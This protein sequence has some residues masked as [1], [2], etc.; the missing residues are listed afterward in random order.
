MTRNSH[1][2]SGHSVPG[3][4]PRSSRRRPHVAPP[5]PQQTGGP[6]PRL[7]TSN[8][9]TQEAPRAVNRVGTATPPR[10]ENPQSL[11]TA[12]R[13]IPKTGRMK[14][15]EKPASWDESKTTV[16]T[17]P[18]ERV[19]GRARG[20]THASCARALL[21]TSPRAARG[22]RLFPRFRRTRPAT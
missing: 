4:V 14:V 7:Q 11:P 20:V 21:P 6:E 19:G 22:P 8:R 15:R 12:V 3:A 17:A 2:Q 13:K 9:H 10:R 16:E 1:L 18:R 5:N